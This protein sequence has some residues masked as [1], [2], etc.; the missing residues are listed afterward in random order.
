[1]EAI[2]LVEEE[3]KTQVI[4][5]ELNWKKIKLLKDLLMNFKVSM[6]SLCARVC[7]CVCSGVQWCAVVD[8]CLCIGIYVHLVAVALASAGVGR[9]RSST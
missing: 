3:N 5:R 2:D 1:M 8:V 4:V 6:F 7:V 9:N